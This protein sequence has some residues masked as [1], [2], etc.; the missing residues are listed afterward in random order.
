MQGHFSAFSLVDRITELEAGKRAKG[1]FE[2]PAHLAGFPVSFAAEAGGQLAAWASS[3]KT[4]QRFLSS[5][6]RAR[7]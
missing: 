5:P 4:R 2:V 1:Y 6:A 3:G 7:I